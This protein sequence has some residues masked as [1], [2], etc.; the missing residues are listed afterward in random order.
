MSGQNVRTHAYMSITEI[1]Q[2]IIKGVLFGGGSE[3]GGAFWFLKILF[4]ISVCYCFVDFLAKYFINKALIVLRKA[5]EAYP[6]RKGDE[7]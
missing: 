2:N 4:M 7:F 5:L 1:I 3:L 6:G